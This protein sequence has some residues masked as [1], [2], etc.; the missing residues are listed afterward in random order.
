M[1]MN[2]ILTLVLINTQV[3]QNARIMIRPTVVSVYVHEQSMMV[4]NDCVVHFI[5]LISNVELGLVHLV[6]PQ[7]SYLNQIAIDE[8]N[9]TWQFLELCTQGNSLLEH[10]PSNFICKYIINA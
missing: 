9:M 6:I 2:E 8:A 5:D 1:F 7:F 4:N 10:Q 3:L